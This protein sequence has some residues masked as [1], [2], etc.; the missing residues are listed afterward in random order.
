MGFTKILV[1]V[2]R[3]GQASAVFEQALEL[4]QKNSAR[5]MVFH[6][7]NPQGEGE[8]APLMGTGVGLDPA[9]GKMVRSLQQER[10]QQDK[11]RSRQLLDSY[12]HRATELGIAAESDCK[13]GEPGLLICE[14]AKSWQADLI[15]L[16]RRGRKG[17][18]EIFLGSVS[19]RVVH[20]AP[21]S[22]LIVQGATPPRSEGK[23]AEC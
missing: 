13:V 19:N 21:C 9:G 10:L 11:E 23:S 8:I 12:S 4:A 3:L 20:N 1:A 15:V 7:V 17:L 2:D 14:A 22:V 6:C 16:G 5:L 18:A